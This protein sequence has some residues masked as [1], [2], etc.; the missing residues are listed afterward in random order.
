M[1]FPGN[2]ISTEMKEM[3]RERN[4]NYLDYSDLTD[5]KDNGMLPFDNAH[6]RPEVYAAIAGQLKKDLEKMKILQNAH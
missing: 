3:L 4:I 6:P 2:P 1:I 5:L